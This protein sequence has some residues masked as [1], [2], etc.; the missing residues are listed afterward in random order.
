MSTLTAETIPYSFSEAHDTI[1]SALERM[2]INYEDWG[3]RSPTKTVND[4][5]RAW[6]EGEILWNPGSHSHILNMH[7]AVARIRSVIGRQRIELRE[8][9]RQ[10]PDGE[11]ETRAHFDGSLAETVKTA[12]PHSEIY[13]DAVVRGMREE[14][15]QTQPKFKDPRNYVLEHVYHSVLKPLHWNR[16]PPFEIIYHREMYEATI[17]YKLYEPEYVCTEPDKTTY[18]GWVTIE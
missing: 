14:L 1:V 13:I 11:K 16:Y 17:D 12:P 4:F 5:V 18:F 8:K 2:N 9:Y 3:T 6:M 15:G 10:F 7:V